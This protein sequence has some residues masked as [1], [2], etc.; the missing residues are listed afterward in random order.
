MRS[1]VLRYYIGPGSYRI[2]FRQ[3]LVGSA[4]Y[5]KAAHRPEMEEEEF[6]SLDLVGMRVIFLS[7]WH[8]SCCFY[9]SLS[10]LG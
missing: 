7:N 3:I 4:I 6:Y 8:E 5:V 9:L 10:C 1:R 2:F